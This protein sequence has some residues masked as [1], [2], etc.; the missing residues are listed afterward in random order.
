MWV[1]TGLSVLYSIVNGLITNDLFTVQT[2]NTA[3]Y[4]GAYVGGVVF[5]AL[6]QVGLWLWM[7]WK[8]RAGRSWARVLS[9]VFFGLT[10]LQTLVV[11]LT[12]PVAAKLLI[13]AYFIVALAAL[14][15]LYQRASS[16]FFSAATLAGNS[17][18]PS[19]MQVGYG[20]PWQGPPGYG[21]P[22]YGPPGYGQPG[23]G[24]PGYGPPGP[25]GYGPP[26]SG[27]QPAQPPQDGGHPPPQ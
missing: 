9:T 25:P 23:Y 8:V 20:Q 4:H 24:P 11:L 26:G 13:T 22:G 16:E 14:I 6:L 12:G 27:Q 18:D 21:Q 3:T 5:E 17:F 15:E 7:L 2:T 1:G 19:Y 10:C